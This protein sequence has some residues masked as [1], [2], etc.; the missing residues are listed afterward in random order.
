MTDKAEGGIIIEA[1]RARAAARPEPKRI[2]YARMQQV[3][4]RQ[5]AALTRARKSGDPEKVAK[6]CRDAVAV[7]NDIGAWPD[8]WRIFE[9]TLNDMLPYHAPV[10][11]RDL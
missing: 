5:K 10:D 1:A 3:F 2:D 6:V 4:P 11:I 7:W 9:R 8:D